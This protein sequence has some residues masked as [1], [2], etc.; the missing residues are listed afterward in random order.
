MRWVRISAA[1]VSIIF[2]F[3]NRMNHGIR[4]PIPGAM[5]AVRMASAMPVRLKRAMA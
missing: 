1:Y 2:A 4:S 3:V 5:R